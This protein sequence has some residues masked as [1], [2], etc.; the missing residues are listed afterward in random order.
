MLINWYFRHQLTE[1][2]R[3][4]DY[5]YQTDTLTGL[6]NR[7]GYYR[8]FE[9][10]YEECRAEGTELAV[11]LI[12]MNG[13]KK[14]NDR[15]GHAEGDFCLR[16]IA[17]AMKGSAAEDEI[18]IRT[19]GDEFVVLAKHYNQEKEQAFTRRMREQIDQTIRRAGKN[20]RISVSVGCCR[21][22]PRNGS[23][24]SIQNEAEV[25]LGKADKAMYAEKHGA[26]ADG[27]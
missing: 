7:R 12:D 5:L 15:Y 3:E 8:F 17:D 10:Y 22:V 9:Q 16:T 6:F 26:P 14:I 19:G 1:T 18:C 24:V 21:G 27:E 2:V 11:F 20:Y 4:L 23:A 13:M 25:F